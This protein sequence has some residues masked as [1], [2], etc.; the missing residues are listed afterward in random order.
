MEVVKEEEQPAIQENYE[1]Q[2]VQEEISVPQESAQEEAQQ[3]EEIE[4][5]DESNVAYY[6]QQQENVREV[7]E[8]V[9]EQVEQ[10]TFQSEQPSESVANQ[11]EESAH[12]EHHHGTHHHSQHHHHASETVQVEV[13]E[14]VSNEVAAPQESYEN[15]SQQQEVLYENQYVSEPQEVYTQET[16]EQEQV[17][18]E[19]Q[20]VSDDVQKEAE[21]VAREA[22]I[23][24]REAEN[25]SQNTTPHQHH[26][27]SEQNYTESYSEPVYT[28]TYASET[29]V[30]VEEPQPVYSS[31][32]EGLNARFVD[33]SSEFVTREPQGGSEWKSR[34]THAEENEIVITREAPVAD[35]PKAHIQRNSEVYRE[36]E[37]AHEHKKASLPPQD[38][39]VQH[40]R[41]QQSSQE[42]GQNTF[43][44]QTSNPFAEF[45][46]NGAV[47]GNSSPTIY[48]NPRESYSTLGQ[49]PYNQSNRT[50]E[51]S[52]NQFG[53]NGIKFSIPARTNERLP[54]FPPQAD[55]SISEDYKSSDKSRLLEV[56][57]ISDREDTSVHR[58]SGA[59]RGLGSNANTFV[60]GDNTTH[61]H[62]IQP[63]PVQVKK[64]SVVEKPAS[65]RPSTIEQVPL[66]KLLI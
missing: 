63:Q 29:R 52:F 3:V 59:N 25:M 60:E 40:H 31:G 10:T 32:Q 8:Q 55:D 26:Y 27:T 44:V 42:S 61:V 14:Q 56:N 24:A 15:S 66:G 5:K 48:E 50:S 9:V 19:Y 51:N 30:V 46:K 36:Q 1:I 6:A 13:Q 20:A 17:A 64:D 34:E 33:N 62:I 4:K 38:D 22:E 23:V 54:T 39:N 41:N 2:G 37:A 65:K 47:T 35:K 7:V 12:H 21:I 18:T 16:R 11:Y 49:N 43:S 45:H 58:P 57:T 53:S 28:S